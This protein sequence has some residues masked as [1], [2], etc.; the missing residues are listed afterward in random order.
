MINSLL[1]LIY[2]GSGLRGVVYLT[3]VLKIVLILGFSRDLLAWLIAPFYQYVFFWFQI[4]HLMIRPYECFECF[5]LYLIYLHLKVN[6]HWGLFIYWDLSLLRFFKK[7]VAKYYHLAHLH[8]PLWFI[9][10]WSTFCS[11]RFLKCPHHII[12]VFLLLCFL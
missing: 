4:F 11:T 9:K 7:N 3:L 5:I 1:Y 12:L 6:L 10:I 8:L 2:R